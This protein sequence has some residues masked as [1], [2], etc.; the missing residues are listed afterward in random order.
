LYDDDAIR[1]K[2]MKAK[3]DSGPTSMNSEMPDYI[4]NIFLLMTLVS[5]EETVSKF[6]NDFNQCTIRYGDLKKQLA[7]DMI[8][9]VRPIREKAAAIEADHQYLASVMKTGAEKARHS[10]GQTMELVRQA[11]GLNYF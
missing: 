5:S 4:Q 9:F 1:K 8:A 2:V 3:T 11:M 6:R 7:E 10:A